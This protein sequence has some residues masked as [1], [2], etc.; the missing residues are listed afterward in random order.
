MVKNYL[1]VLLLNIFFVI[2]FN[3]LDIKFFLYFF[4]LL[5]F[6]FFKCVK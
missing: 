2:Y 5:M 4:V 6:R 3:V 1:L